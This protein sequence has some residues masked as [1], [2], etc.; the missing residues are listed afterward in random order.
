MYKVLKNEVT[1]AVQ[2]NMKV[3]GM[4]LF[5]RNCCHQFST[6]LTGVYSK[7]VTVSH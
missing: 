4:G 6:Q 5:K 3:V 2:F 1:A 7:H